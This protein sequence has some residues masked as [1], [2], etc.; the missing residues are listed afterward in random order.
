MAEALAAT[1]ITTTTTTVSVENSI[2]KTCDKEK[3]NPEVKHVKIIFS[4]FVVVS[5][6]FVGVRERVKRK[7][8]TKT[9]TECKSGNELKCSMIIFAYQMYAEKMTLD[10]YA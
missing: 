10:Y 1:K 6:H 9:N 4:S 2:E 5:V 7:D 8:S 3:K